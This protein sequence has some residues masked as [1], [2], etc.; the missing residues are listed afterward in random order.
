MSIDFTTNSRAK[1]RRELAF[2]M[3]EMIGVLVVIALLAAIL[4]PHLIRQMDQIAGNRESAYLQSL[5]GAFQQS[6]LRNRSISGNTNWPSIVATEL[7]VDIS[8]VTTNSRK[9]MRV[10]LIDP[11]MQIGVNGGRVPYTQNNAGSTVTN[12]SGNVIAPVRARVMILS[13]MGP[14]LPAFPANGIPT[15]ND[16]TNIWNV[17]ERMVP[18]TPVFTNWTGSGDD[19]K[20][21]RINL[22]PLFVRLVLTTYAATNSSSSLLGRYS[23]DWQAT[24][25]VPVNAITNPAGIEGYFIQNSILG[26]HKDSA[27]GGVLDSQQV[28]IRNNSFVYDE[29]VWRGSITGISPL[30]G[31]DIG[32]VVDKFLAAYQNPRAPTNQQVTVVQSMVNYM[33]AYG[34]WAAA[35]F[36]RAGNN[37]PA[38]MSA[39]QSAMRTAVQTLYQGAYY[40]NEVP[41]PP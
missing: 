9:Q 3:I 20:I 26:L 39:A 4:L 5:S 27:S 37:P 36:P 15:D 28:L 31:M 40:P 17:A 16:F 21:Q 2:T 32:S 11:S 14:A 35:G 23:I 25:T 8:N 29:R 22:S 41:C 33:N 30:G 24:N 6:I 38:Y 1:N 10:M 18:P 7:G 19:L 13:S 34:T 12:G